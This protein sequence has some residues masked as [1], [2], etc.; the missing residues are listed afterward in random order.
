MKKGD[1]NRLISWVAKWGG[2]FLV[3]FPPPGKFEDA[4]WFLLFQWPTVHTYPSRKRSFSKRSLNRR[5]MKTPPFCFRVEGHNFEHGSLRKQPSF[6]A[7]SPSDEKDATRALMSSKTNK[8]T[9]KQTNNLVVKLSLMWHL[10][11]IMRSFA[12][13]QDRKSLDKSL[14]HP[15]K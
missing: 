15:L 8:Q 3:A 14:N 11:A 4:D 6:F 7:H 9:N 13:G 10:P 2:L 5:N 12:A 1:G